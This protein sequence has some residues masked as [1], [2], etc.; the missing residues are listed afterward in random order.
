MKNITDVAGEPLTCPFSRLSKDFVPA[1]QPD[2][3][4]HLTDA[5]E[6]KEVFL[7]TDDFSPANA[8]TAVRK[9]N[10]ASL[11]ILAGYRFSLPPVLASAEGELHRRVRGIV[12]KFFTPA[13]VRRRSL[14][15]VRLFVMSWLGFRRGRVV[16]FPSVPCGWF[17]SMRCFS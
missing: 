5:D 11:R 12:A 15:F 13:K 14:G 7:R 9:L 2:P 3:Y 8:L 17:R 4:I 10:P 6:I 16:I 1:G